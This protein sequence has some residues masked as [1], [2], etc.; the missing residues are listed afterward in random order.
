MCCWEG[1]GLLQVAARLVQERRLVALGR[2]RDDDRVLA[3]LLAE[4]ARVVADV[5]RV[6]GRVNEPR[7]RV[8]AHEAQHLL[9]REVERARAN[10]RAAAARAVVTLG[11]GDRTRE[12][13]AQ[14]ERKVHL[15]CRGG[16]R[17]VGRNTSGR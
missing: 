1:L 5:A 14:A 13:L 11:L 3:L 12:P 17:V 10:R 4:A 16:T 8:V 7:E 6:L 15:V 2:R 9:V